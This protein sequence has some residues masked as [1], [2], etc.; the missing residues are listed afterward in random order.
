MGQYDNSANFGKQLILKHLKLIMEEKGITMYKLSK[1]TGI[2]ES[3]LSLNFREETQM[4]LLNFL[5][6]CGA[7]NIKPYLIPVELDP[8]DM[9]NS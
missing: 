2:S 9:T 5:K 7:L 3:V 1:L 6:I 8:D 4:T